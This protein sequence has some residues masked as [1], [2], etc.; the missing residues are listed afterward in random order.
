MLVNSFFLLI[1]Y[2][3]RY[4]VRFFLGIDKVGIYSVG[5]ALGMFIIAIM[6]P[7]EY[8]LYPKIA[9]YWNNNEMEKVKSYI[10][11]TLSL[12]VPIAVLT[13]LLMII[14]AK[15]IV[16]MVSNEAF[17][18]AVPTVPYL[19]LGFLIFGIGIIGERIITLLNKTKML[20]YIYSSL[21]VFNIFLNILLVPR[22]G[23]QGAALATF[24]TFTLYSLI[25]LGIAHRY[26]V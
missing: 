19:T 7:F 2:G 9:A 13:C 10:K 22:L 11:K 20:L 26:I 25:T 8:V 14:F 21:A 3:D 5:Y 4:I 24:M 16:G 23:I 18:S 1:N 17:I 6:R 12:S 15:Q